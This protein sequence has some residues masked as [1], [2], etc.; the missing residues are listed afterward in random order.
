MNLSADTV[1]VPSAPVVS[2]P[3]LLVVG[4]LSTN[5]QMYVE[6][7]IGKWWNRAVGVFAVVRFQSVPVP[8]PLLKQLADRGW[9]R[10]P[11]DHRNDVRTADG[12]RRL[13]GC[14]HDDGDVRCASHECRLVH[15]AECF[16]CVV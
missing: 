12:G 11:E 5:A 6:S 15:G 14:E 8:Y 7:R 2:L 16:V 4:R 10:R 1:Y 13:D 3:V 9:I